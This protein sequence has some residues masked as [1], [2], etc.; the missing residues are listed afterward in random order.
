MWKWMRPTCEGQS[1]A[2]LGGPEVLGA[3]QP[4]GAE[5][6]GHAVHFKGRIWW[7]KGGGERRL[8][9][10]SWWERGMKRC[11]PENPNDQNDLFS[12]STTCVCGSQVPAASMCWGPKHAA[13]SF[14]PLMGLWSGPGC[15][16]SNPCGV[17]ALVCA[18]LHHMMVVRSPEGLL[19]SN[20]AP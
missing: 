15:L 5:L 2:G 4:R 14:T 18:R 7:L 16:G 6:T 10:G 12:V 8:T 20:R 17:K 19:D 13:S 3:R 1:E 11:R 9:W